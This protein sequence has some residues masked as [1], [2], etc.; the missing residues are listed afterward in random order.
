MM[1]LKL[2]E[3]KVAKTVDKNSLEPTRGRPRSHI[4]KKG[5]FSNLIETW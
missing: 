2:H 5:P 4:P 3:G 1:P